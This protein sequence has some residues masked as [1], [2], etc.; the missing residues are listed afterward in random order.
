VVSRQFIEREEERYL[1]C[2]Q[3][4]LHY[5]WY[6]MAEKREKNYFRVNSGQDSTVG[7]VCYIGE[8]IA[9]YKPDSF[10]RQMI[11]F[12]HGSCTVVIVVSR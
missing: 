6:K 4:K 3:S 9:A 2:G 11:D 8:S 12:A 10:F 7:S 5:W 1:P